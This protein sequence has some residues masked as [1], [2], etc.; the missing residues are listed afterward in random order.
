[1]QSPRA[2]LVIEQNKSAIDGLGSRRIGVD[3]ESALRAA[4]NKFRVRF[5]QVEQLASA[6][7]IDLHASDLATLDAL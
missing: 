5:E 3:P 1:M 6:R 7:E 4:T 2:D